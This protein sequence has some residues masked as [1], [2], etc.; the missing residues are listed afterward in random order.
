MAD[1][2]I[3]ILRAAMEQRKAAGLTPF[4]RAG[5]GDLEEVIELRKRLAELEAADKNE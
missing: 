2:Q 5:F 1:K 4:P 3:E